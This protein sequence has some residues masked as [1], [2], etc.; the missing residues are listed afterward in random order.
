MAHENEKI[1]FDGKLLDSKKLSQLR[2]RGISFVPQS[3]EHLDP[4]MRVGDQMIGACAR[5]DRERRRQRPGVRPGPG[6]GL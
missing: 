3:V 5:A 4:L 6:A 1:W 2:G